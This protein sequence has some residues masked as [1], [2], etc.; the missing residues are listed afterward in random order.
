MRRT[1]FPTES[2]YRSIL[3]ISLHPPS[4][5]TPKVHQLTSVTS[6][7]HSK[8]CF[9]FSL[10]FCTQFRSTIIVVD[11][12]LLKKFETVLLSFIYEFNLYFLFL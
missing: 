12:R 8:Q 11:A 7:A 2:L 4:T 10:Q 9:D 6:P 1:G 5:K 3:K